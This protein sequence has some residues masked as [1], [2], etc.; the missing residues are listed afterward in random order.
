MSIEIK[1]EDII[2]HGLNVLQLVGSHYICKVCINSGNSCCKG[3]EFLKDGFGCQKRNTSCTAW[4]CGL[5]K[6][7]LN[8][9][10]LLDEWENLWEQVPGQWFRRDNT[11]E[12]IKI[13]SLLNIE[14]L[15]SKVGKL[16]ATKLELFVKEG[17]NVDKL[18]RKL[19]LDFELR[20]SDNIHPL[21]RRH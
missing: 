21:Y 19:N 12:T 6:F 16:I 15:D 14:Q 17:G 20:N 9:I 8:E 4:L 5:Q 3:C 18:E 1:R 10:G 13:K 2:Q 7:F 11:P